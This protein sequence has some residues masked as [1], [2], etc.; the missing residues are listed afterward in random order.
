MS[1][2]RSAAA[3]GG[4]VGDLGVS[5]GAS[6]KTAATKQ[7]RIKGASIVNPSS[8]RSVWKGHFSP[9]VSGMDTGFFA[10]EGKFVMT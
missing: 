1:K 3:S 9:Y 2:A 7:K 10:W 6:G 8:K 5:T 4:G